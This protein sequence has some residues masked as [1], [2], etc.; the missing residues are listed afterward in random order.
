MLHPDLERAV[1]AADELQGLA[2]TRAINRA[3]RKLDGGSEL[4][5]AIKRTR[6]HFALCGEP[7]EGLAYALALD[8]E[9]SRVVN[10]AY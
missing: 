2:N 8:A 4:E 1:A 5:R 3:F 6:A 9:L 10:S 7:C